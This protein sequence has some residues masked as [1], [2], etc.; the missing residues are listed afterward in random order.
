MAR[1]DNNIEHDDTERALKEV[2]QAE[3]DAKRAVHDCEERAN[4]LLAEARDRARR[5]AEHADARIST[6]EARC[7]RATTQ[8]LDEIARADA[9]HAAAI[10]VPRAEHPG[11]QRAVEALA[12]E[13][14]GTTTPSSDDSPEATPDTQ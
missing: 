9:A 12:A 1:Q 14:I 6:L 5:I 7:E 3:Q 2:L 4:A 13:L 11:T 8:R 10:A